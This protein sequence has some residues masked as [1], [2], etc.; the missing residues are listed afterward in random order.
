MRDRSRRSCQRIGRAWTSGPS[1]YSG[2]LI[3]IIRIIMSG[4]CSAEQLGKLLDQE[5]GVLIDIARV[6]QLEADS[7]AIIPQEVRRTC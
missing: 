7:V 2:S 6:D 3:P 1:K 4:S 5:R